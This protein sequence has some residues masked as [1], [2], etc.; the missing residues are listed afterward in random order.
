MAKHGLGAELP[1]KMI[2][3]VLSRRVV[4][5]QYNPLQYLPLAE[6]VP[7]R[8]TASRQE[9]GNKTP[10]PDAQKVSPGLRNSRLSR[11]N[12]GCKN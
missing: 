9:V 1:S 4:M 3:S 5:V 8:T 11:R 12:N 2:K 10:L 6:E 7:T